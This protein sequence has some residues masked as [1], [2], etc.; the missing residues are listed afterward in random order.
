MRSLVKNI[1]NFITT[2]NLV[3]GLVGIDLAYDG[4]LAAAALMIVLGNLLDFADGLVARLLKTSSELGGELDSLADLV[5]FGVLPGVILLKMLYNGPEPMPVTWLVFLVPV[6]AAW[7]LAKFNIDTRQTDFFL[8]VPT[9]LNALVIGSL[10]L[11]QQF[12][13]ELA[14]LIEQP[15]VLLGIALLLSVL[16]VVELPLLSFKIKNFGWQE[17]SIR[18]TFVALSALLF[19]MLQ[20]RAMPLIFAL[21][22]LLSGVK[23]WGR[24]AGQ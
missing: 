2:G 1:P 18:Y 20:T 11:I 7:R 15:V 21:Y 23:Y 9:P 12:H 8:G 14:P 24:K 13:P 19:V 6:C 16:M 17:N 3:S 22:L 4:H 10:P 5:T